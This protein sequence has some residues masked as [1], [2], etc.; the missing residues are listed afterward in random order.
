MR[1]LLIVSI[2]MATVFAGCGTEDKKNFT[3][4]ANKSEGSENMKISIT[5][6]RQFEK[7]NWC[8]SERDSYTKD[9]KFEAECLEVATEFDPMFRGEAAGRWYVI[10]RIGRFSPTVVFY[11]FEPPLPDALMVM[12]LKQMI[13]HTIQFAAIHRAPAKISIVSPEGEVFD[14][15]EEEL[16]SVKKEA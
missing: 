14:S 10:R 5:I 3:M 9:G 7:R 6:A 12:Q 16:V 13:P 8:E 15:I 11:E 4:V 1:Q 2:F